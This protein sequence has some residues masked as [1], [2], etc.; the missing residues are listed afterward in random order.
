MILCIFSHSEELPGRESQVTCGFSTM[1]ST[2]AWPPRNIPTVICITLGGTTVFLP[3]WTFFGHDGFLHMALLDK[4]S[5]FICDNKNIYVCECLFCCC[6]VSC[7]LDWNWTYYIIYCLLRPFYMC[8]IMLGIHCGSIS[9][10]LLV[11]W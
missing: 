2:N 3:F 10:T 9:K 8:H 11:Y 4:I 1:F 7:W 6:S 5:N